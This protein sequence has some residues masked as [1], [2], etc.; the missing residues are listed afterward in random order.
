MRFPSSC[1]NRQASAAPQPGVRHDCRA[2]RG[3]GRG[4]G[5]MGASACLGKECRVLD[6]GESEVGQQLDGEAVAVNGEL[7]LCGEA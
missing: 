6:A 3:W 1:G 5:C 7:L 4:G 2:L